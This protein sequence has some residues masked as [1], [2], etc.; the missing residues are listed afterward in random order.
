MAFVSSSRRNSVVSGTVES[1]SS[2]LVFWGFLDFLP[3]H[4][5]E[6][7]LDFLPALCAGT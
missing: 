7:V 6:V 5:A 2:Q 4:L 3:P 1:V